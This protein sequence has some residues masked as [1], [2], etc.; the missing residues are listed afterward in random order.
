MSYRVNDDARATRGD[1]FTTIFT[2]CKHFLKSGNFFPN[3]CNP[4]AK[5]QA[6]ANS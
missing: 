3:R 2:S 1:Y 5:Q 6:I 4:E